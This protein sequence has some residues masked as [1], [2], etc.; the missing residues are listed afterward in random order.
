M[1]SGG[2]KLKNDFFSIL[3]IQTV[4]LILD[5]ES[6]SKMDPFLM[7]H[8]TEIQKVEEWSK[9]VFL[10]ILSPLKIHHFFHL[11]PHYIAQSYLFFM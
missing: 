4:K 8:V 5:I 10:A 1:C 11:Q 3:I 7:H 2:K 6:I 9:M